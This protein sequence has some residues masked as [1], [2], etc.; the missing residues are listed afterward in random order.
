VIDRS[1]SME[2]EKMDVVKGAA[3]QLVRALRPQDIFSVVAFSDRAEVIIP[4]AFQVDRAKLENRIQMIQNSGAT[5][6]Y[7]GLEA[8]LQRSP[9][10]PRPAVCKSPHPADRRPYLW[11]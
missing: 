4:A 8:G 7:Q 10:Q 1:T 9:P 2:G 3:S 11:R 5:E 6:I